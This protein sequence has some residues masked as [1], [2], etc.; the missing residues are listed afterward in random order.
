MREKYVTANK[1]K[2]DN[3]VIKIMRKEN[4]EWKRRR[5][6]LVAPHNIFLVLINSF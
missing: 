3:I 5:D 1:R 2:R 6:H 4:K